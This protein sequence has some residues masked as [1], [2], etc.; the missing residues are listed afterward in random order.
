MLEIQADN[1]SLQQS[2]R[3]VY[4]V[5]STASQS[6][7]DFGT[8]VVF[9]GHTFTSADDRQLLNISL[10]AAALAAIGH[11]GATLTLSGRVLPPTLFGPTQLSEFAFAGASPDANLVLTTAGGVPEPAS[12][13]LMIAGCGLTG[14]A[15]RRR[16]AGTLPA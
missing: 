5:T 12:W 3:F 15:L 8:G 13:A 14:A 4:Q 1:V 6:F 9:G 10:D 2:A 11:G 16:R 7:G